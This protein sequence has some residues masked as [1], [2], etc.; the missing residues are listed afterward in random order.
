MGLRLAVTGR[1]SKDPLSLQH[2]EYLPR[3]NLRLLGCAV[4]ELFE[5]KEPKFPLY[6]SCQTQP[7]SFS[8]SLLPVP[9]TTHCHYYLLWGVGGEVV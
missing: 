1:K 3:R 9:W 6:Y 5:Q 2:S 7:E 8:G 4:T